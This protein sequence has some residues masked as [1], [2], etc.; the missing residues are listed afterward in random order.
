[1][2]AALWIRWTALLHAE[3]FS[4]GADPSAIWTFFHSYLL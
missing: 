1:M 3:G 2:K 4:S